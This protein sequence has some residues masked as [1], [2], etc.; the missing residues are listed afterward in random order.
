M[1]N[2]SCLPARLAARAFAGLPYRP[3][4]AVAGLTLLML[5]GCA[6]PPRHVSRPLPPPPVAMEPMYFYPEREQGAER[7]DRDRYECYRWA[8]RETNFDPGMRPVQRT[9]APPPVARDPGAAVAG[10]VT[11]AV[12]GAAVSSP[13]NVGTGLVL[14]AIFGSMVGAAAEESRAEAVEQARD[15]RRAEWDARQQVP[16]SNFRRAMSACMGGR[17]YAVR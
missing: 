14:G 17:G 1:V 12:V 4:L 5:A 10:G 2:L 6:A 8:V 11:G 13:R 16:L 9:P 7:Q 15:A 3:R